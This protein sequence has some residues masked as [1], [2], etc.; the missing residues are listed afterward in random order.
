[1]DQTP[2][3]ATGQSSDL[4]SVASSATGGS[5][6]LWAYGDMYKAYFHSWF[7]TF[8]TYTDSFSEAVW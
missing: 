2:T 5:A 3:P 8:G 6:E 7:I 4:P 1:M